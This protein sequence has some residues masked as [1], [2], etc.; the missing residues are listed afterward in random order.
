MDILNT[1]INK[2]ICA[3]HITPSSTGCFD[4]RALDRIANGYNEN[5]RDKII[6]NKTTSDKKLWEM[7]N[8]RIERY[9]NN[10]EICWLRS[11]L[12]QN[13]SELSNYFKPQKPF[14]QYEWLKT[15][16]INAVLKQY[17]LKYKDFTFFGAVPIDFDLIIREIAFIN[18]CKLIHSGKTKL[19]FVFNLDP[20]TKSGSHWVALYMDFT[21]RFIGF[22][23]STGNLPPKEIS[24]LMEKL[25]MQTQK[26]TGI[27][28]NVKI[29]H[30]ILVGKLKAA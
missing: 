28:L 14:G 3:P 24:K 23:D 8:N 10:G 22:F 1:N 29:N 9:C 30:N 25:L 15:S 19:G 17:E 16:S 20:H 2:N 6:F 27:R 26:C 11:A 7:I 5:N 13:D 4:R 21:K 18:V 12:I